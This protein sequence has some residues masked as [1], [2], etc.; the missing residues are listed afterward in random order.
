MALPSVEVPNTSEEDNSISKYFDLGS[1]IEKFES[2]RKW[3][4]D[5]EHYSDFIKE[6]EFED[7]LATN[8]F[9]AKSILQLFLFTQQY[10]AE[11]PKETTSSEK[12]ETSQSSKINFGKFP[13]RVFLDFRED[14]S[15]CYI[16]GEMMKYKWNKGWSRFDLGV[17]EKRESTF[18]MLK[19]IEKLL[20]DKCYLLIPRI[21]FSSDVEPEM[22]G[23][24][25]ETIKKYQGVIVE[26]EALASHVVHGS[27]SSVHDLNAKG[28]FVRPVIVE[29][30]FC[31]LH[32]LFE[33]LVNLFLV[34][35]EVLPSEFSSDLEFN[36]HNSCSKYHVHYDWITQLEVTN[37]WMVELDFLTEKDNQKDLLELS[38]AIPVSS[39]KPSATFNPYK[40]LLPQDSEPSTNSH[41]LPSNVIIQKQPTPDLTSCFSTPPSANHIEDVTD[42]MTPKD[43]ESSAASGAK[44][45]FLDLDTVNHYIKRPKLEDC[46]DT[47]A[48][49]AAQSFHIIIPAYSSWF[50]YK[51]IHPIERRALPEYFN[52]KNSTKTPN[53]YMHMRNYLIDSYRINPFIYLTVTCARRNLSGDVCSVARVHAFLEQWGLINYQCNLEPKLTPSNAPSLAN[54]ATFNVLG[55][56]KAKVSPD[57]TNH[58]D[59]SAKM[60]TI[61][62]PLNFQKTINASDYIVNFPPVISSNQSD[63]LL[64]F[65]LNVDL[66]SPKKKVSKSGNATSH[67]DWTQTETFLLLEG[68]QIYEED[69]DKISDHV[70]T[71]NSEQCVMQFL[72]LPIEDPYLLGDKN[73]R[74]KLY[75]PAPFANF[76]NPV[77]TT[78]AFLA[79]EV[80]GRIAAEA[81]KAALDSLSRMSMQAV[82][83]DDHRQIHNFAESINPTGSA[84][85]SEFEP[86][87][88]HEASGPDSNDECN[89]NKENIDINNSNSSSS[90]AEEGYNSSP[91]EEREQSNTDSNDDEQID[92]EA[93]VSNDFV[94][95][96]PP[97]MEFDAL[98]EVIED[99]QEAVS[100]LSFERM[101][102]I[103]NVPITKKM[104]LIATEYALKASCE[105]AKQL[106]ELIE[107]RIRNN[108]AT[109][110]EIQIKKLELKMKHYEELEAILEKERSDYESKKQ[111]VI[112]ER[113]QFL[114]QQMTNQFD[115]S[116]AN[117][118]NHLQSSPLSAPMHS[119][120]QHITPRVE[121]NVTVG[122]VSSYSAN[123]HTNSGHT[124]PTSGFNP[125]PVATSVVTWTPSTYASNSIVATCAQ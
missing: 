11:K 34:P 67:S 8:R 91:D 6:E 10:Q 93:V 28:Q 77:M 100:A 32:F 16:L 55:D 102:M 75:E 105:K 17:Q 72:K 89:S 14:G 40:R 22:V 49:F 27:V 86:E 118:M 15:L 35:S 96:E 36:L 110:V 51:Q 99:N 115:G 64:N 12:T 58:P 53:V 52:G 71:K 59:D 41:Q 73:T 125:N 29:N 103:H 120:S 117:R 48:K 25:S 81:A 104:S 108:V 76:P 13:L 107:K 85:P 23:Q 121:S 68:V 78:V 70:G 106:Q 45:E 88:S 112:Q 19:L 26:T 109:L 114:K 111:T 5:H 57:Q 38:V 1:T 30:N 94:I 90:S 54:P 98:P 4:M 116:A 124:V 61:V 56:V 3:L 20:I 74:N 65:G 18:E 37:E 7:R 50:N 60:P 47:S 80:D 97:I 2:I 66:Y 122:S 21:F 39:L 84:V 113:Q 87:G 92:T 42:K 43:C 119:S 83:S 62:A 79:R 31:L 33:P 24:L 95:S 63:S 82:P 46:S 123:V 101:E 69:W 9:L 44:T